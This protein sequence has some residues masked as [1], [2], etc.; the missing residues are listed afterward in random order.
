MLA[1]KTAILLFLKAPRPGTVKTRLAQTVGE[2]RATAA[3][4]ALVER[5]ITA[6]QKLESDF[7]IEIHYAPI[8]AEPEM[9]EWLGP[10]TAFFPQYEGDLGERLEHAVASA[11]QRSAAHVICIGGDCPGLNAKHFNQTVEHLIAGQDLVIGPSEDGGYY[12]I[13]TRRFIPELFRGI[14]WSASNTREA[15]IQK[16][17]E[18]D[19]Q[20]VFLETLYDVDTQAELNRA[21]SNGQLD[22]Q[23]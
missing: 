2:A 20:T 11:F 22:L 6:L 8:S 10:K 14:P 12:L 9:T 19:L 1:S 18:M 3:Y 4:R 7:S 21:I 23:S 17:N 16:A 5:Q 15:T 13:A